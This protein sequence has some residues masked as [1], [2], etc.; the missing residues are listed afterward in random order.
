MNEKPKPLLQLELPK[1]P[2]E[3]IWERARGQFWLRIA[4]RSTNL[5]EGPHLEPGTFRPRN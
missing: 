1:A 5:P 3:D 2:L 4:L